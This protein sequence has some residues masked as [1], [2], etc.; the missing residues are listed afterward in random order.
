MGRV[1]DDQT[2]GRCL[3]LFDLSI[4]IKLTRKMY[5]ITCVAHFNICHR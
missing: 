1:D 5:V 2:A 3:A 4:D